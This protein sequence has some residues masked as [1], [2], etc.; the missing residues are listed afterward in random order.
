MKIWF[1][2]IEAGSGTDV[3]TVRLANSLRQHGVEAHISYFPKYYEFAPFLLGRHR[4]P[5]G[6]DI[7]HTNSWS[8]FAFKGHGIP[9]VTTVHL[10]VMDSIYSEHKSLAQKLYHQLLIKRYEQA[11]MKYA[12]RI[13]TVSDFVGT[14]INTTYG[15]VKSETIYNF[16]NTNKFR[17]N[18]EKYKKKN[19]VF[20]LLFIGNLIRRKGSDLLEPIMDKL[21]EKFE[22]YAT[23]GLSS[24]SYS[25]KSK[26]IHNI[27]RLIGDDVVAAYQKADA[28]LFPT[29]LEGFGYSV[30]EAMACGLPV[31]TSR[32]SSLPEITID[33]ETGILCKTGDVDEFANACRFL[34]NNPDKCASYGQNGQDRV[35]SK[36]SESRII[37]QYIKLYKDLANR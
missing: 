37:D 10:P 28:L 31:I 14:S 27:G 24:H 29:R 2:L 23:T 1:P 7:I 20:R 32:N 6:T 16:I 9:L 8:A 30:L 12:N 5:A 22:L 17:P 35:T 21:G 19:G 36:F 18:S 11:S 4:P 26:N 3:Y 25:L 13:T 15:K 33:G 34:R